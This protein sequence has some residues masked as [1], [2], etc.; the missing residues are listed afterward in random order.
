MLRATVQSGSPLGNQLNELMQKGLLVPNELVLDML[1]EAM[2]AKASESKGYLIDG[3]PRQ[4]D[5]GIQFENE[6]ILTIEKLNL[7]FKFWEFKDC[8]MQPCLVR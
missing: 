6:V 7:K 2:I 8:H 5:Q 1:K 4:V 3:Y